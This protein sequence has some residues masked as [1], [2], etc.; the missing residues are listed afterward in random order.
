MPV[1]RARI[2][3]IPP[4]SEFYHHAIITP[5]PCQTE[6]SG[7]KERKA[8]RSIIYSPG[9]KLLFTANIFA[10]TLAVNP[11]TCLAYCSTCLELSSTSNRLGSC[12]SLKS[13]CHSSSGSGACFAATLA[14]FSAF[15][16]CC[17]AVIFAC[18]RP[19]DRW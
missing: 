18:S 14:A 11:S 13:L 1:S 6:S 4:E 8:S 2:D 12:G 15:R 16:F 17:H 9:S 19:S 5:C 10:L 7:L 3:S